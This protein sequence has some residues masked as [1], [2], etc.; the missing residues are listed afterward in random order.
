ME[1]IFIG[2]KGTH[3]A[4]FRLVQA[5]SGNPYFLTNSFAGLKKDMD[6]LGDS[7]GCAIMFGCDKNL[8]DAV[9]IEKTAQCENGI[10]L[11]SFLDVERISES[12]TAEGVKN[13]I[14]D[15][16]TQYLC[17]TAYWYALRKFDGKAVLIH[18]PTM[19]YADDAFIQKIKRAF[20]R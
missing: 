2:F 1:N 14:S 3:N 10:K 7:Y 9:R 4:S 20:S 19:K 6:A 18:M 17:N 12:L 16:P 11:H 8:K 5:L 15:N 13:I